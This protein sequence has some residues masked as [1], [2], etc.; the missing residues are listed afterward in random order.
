VRIVLLGPQGSGK[1]THAELLSQRIQAEHIAMGDIVRAEIRL[2]TPLGESLR[3]Y[4]D[5]GELV[6]DE[7]I[8]RLIRPVLRANTH[9]ILDGFPRDTAQARALD[10]VLR[11]EKCPL[12][13]VVA[14]E[15]REEPLL[16][17]LANRRQSEST[18]AVY[19]LVSYP[20]P[21]HDVGPFVR[22]TDDA[23][24]KIRRRLEL[25]RNVTE[26]LK[27]YY[28]EQGLLVR[29]DADGSID[30]VQERILRA[31]ELD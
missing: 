5:R 18:G 2:G 7:L 16:E 17:R 1:G 27:Q 6:P 29:V 30:E 19:N 28:D 9:W 23:P 10:D 22:R 13:R 8:L 26:P 21:P 25:Y 20:P 14:L 24:E 12:D 3:Q 15:I 4:N 11:E 31:L